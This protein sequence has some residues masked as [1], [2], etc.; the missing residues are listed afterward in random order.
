MYIIPQ[1]VMPPVVPFVAQVPA[2]GVVSWPL[3]L[4][5]AVWLALA[6][7]VGTALGILREHTSGRP[8]PQITLKGRLSRPQQPAL[9]HA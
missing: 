2:A 7:L 3:G 8:V 6:A 5:V 9:R 1:L 4:Q